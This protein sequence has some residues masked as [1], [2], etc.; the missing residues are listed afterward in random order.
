M[1]A[2]ERTGLFLRSLFLQAAF[3]PERMQG[4]G[5]AWALDPWLVKVW[6]RDAG[7]LAAARLR[8]LGCFNTNPYA[9]GFVLGLVARLEQDAAAAPASERGERLRRAAQ[10]KAAASAGL[11]GA[12]DSFFW[13]ALRQALAFAALLSGLLL[14]SLGA[15]AWAA[16]PAA[17]YL[18]GWNVPALVARWRGLARGYAGGERAVLEVC[19]LPAAQAAL[20]TRFAALGLGAAAVMAALYCGALHQNARW[21][22]GVAFLLALAA[23]ERVGPWGVAAGAGALRAIWE[24][25]L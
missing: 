10:L 7:A 22:G 21:I 3:S 9:V 16:A 15:G 18:A 12:A 14:L 13:G 24:A 8:H 23:P 2:W 20:A 4:L 25:G 11:A 19:R 1:S 17:L 6:G 5:F